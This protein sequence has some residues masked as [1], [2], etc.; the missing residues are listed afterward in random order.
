MFTRTEVW[1]K[2]KHFA[3]CGER[4]L[5]VELDS[6]LSYDVRFPFEQSEHSFSE[7][8]A[9]EGGMGGILMLKNCM[10]LLSGRLSE[11][12]IR[13]NETLSLLNGEYE[14]KVMKGV[15]VAISEKNMALAL[16]YAQLM[17][18][19]EGLTVAARMAQKLRQEELA[20][21]IEALA[22]EKKEQRPPQSGGGRTEN[23]P[24]KILLEDYEGLDLNNIRLKYGSR[25]EDSLQEEGRA[26]TEGEGEGKKVEQE[27][28][29]GG[30]GADPAG[31]SGSSF[32]FQLSKDTEEILQMQK[33]EETKREHTLTS[34]EQ[35]GPGGMKREMNLG[36][37]RGKIFGKAKQGATQGKKASF[38]DALKANPLMPKKRAKKQ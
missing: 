2:I 7:A 8:S 35:V 24:L 5:S 17:L 36:G 14:K 23:N 4:V 3:S 9:E 20:E 1:L 10:G 13:R 25:A 6:I 15:K 28:E 11:E 16:D 38:M 29:V 32:S 27:Y 33:T 31:Y 19:R 18:T 21:R 30:V 22:L 12:Q 34:E 26:Y 37:A